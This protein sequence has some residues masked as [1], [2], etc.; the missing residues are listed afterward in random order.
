MHKQVAPQRLKI[1]VFLVCLRQFF[2]IF[3]SVY[4]QR[5]WSYLLA[6]YFEILNPQ[7]TLK[8][9][10]QLKRKWFQSLYAKI[11]TLQTFMNFGVYLLSR[12]S[13]GEQSNCKCLQNMV[14]F[15]WQWHA[16]W[17]R[18]G[19]LSKRSLLRQETFN[20]F[21]AVE[22]VRLKLPVVNMG[23]VSN[24]CSEFGSLMTSACCHLLPRGLNDAM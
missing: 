4:A 8:K 13:L 18:Q 15:L 3:E 11:P 5:C 17:L 12:D 10:R 20:Y 24:I 6:K 1:K 16:V 23:A 7:L 19:S 22:W 2:S 14:P 21:E 9:H